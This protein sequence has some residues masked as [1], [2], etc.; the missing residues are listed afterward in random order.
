MRFGGVFGRLLNA[1]RPSFT[2]KD[3]TILVSV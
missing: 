2:E 3:L 1:V